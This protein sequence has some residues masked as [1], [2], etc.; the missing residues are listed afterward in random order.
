MLESAPLLWSACGND[1][2]L[3][4]EILGVWLL[5]IFGDD[6]L[7]VILGGKQTARQV[8]AGRARPRGLGAIWL[9]ILSWITP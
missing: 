5:E 9:R 1:L 8:D 7:N 2:P 4:A 6:H 3:E